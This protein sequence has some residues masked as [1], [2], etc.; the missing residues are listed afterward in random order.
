MLGMCLNGYIFVKFKSNTE[1]SEN[2]VIVINV[3]RDETLVLPWE[4]PKPIE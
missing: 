1:Y 3:W 4:L 2:K